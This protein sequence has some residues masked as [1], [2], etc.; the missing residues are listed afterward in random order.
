MAFNMGLS[1]GVGTKRVFF[2]LSLP[3]GNPLL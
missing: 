1:S 2:R 3:E